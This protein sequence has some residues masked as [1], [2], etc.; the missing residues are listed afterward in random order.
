M[1]VATPTILP[2]PMVADSAVH[3]APKE[4]TSPSPLSS[5]LTINFS[6]LPRCSTCTKP[7]RTVSHTPAAKIKMISGQPHTAF[8]T[9]PMMSSTDIAS[10]IVCIVSP[11]LQI[12]KLI[13]V[14]HKPGDHSMCK[15]QKKEANMYFYTYPP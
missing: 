4:V 8:C 5:F 13:Q 11:F 12:K 6:A 15:L 2:V 10:V 14:Y 1:A 3:S 9:L 7:V